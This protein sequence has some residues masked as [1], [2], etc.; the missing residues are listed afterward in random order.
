MRAERTLLRRA[1]RAAGACLLLSGW[2]ATA[3]AQGWSVQFEQAQ[4]AD[5]VTLRL[6][7]LHNPGGTPVVL[8]HGIG[9][10]A[11]EFLLPGRALGE[12][13]AGLG[14]D[15]WCANFRYAGR[16]QLASDDAG[17][18]SFDALVAFDLPAIL[19]RVRAASGGARP[20]LLGHSMGGMV[21]LAWA[22]GIERARV[23]VSLRLVLRGGRLR[24]EPV[25][26]WRMR[27][28]PALAA[29]RAAE[30]R[31]VIAIGSPARLRWPLVLPRLDPDLYW[32]VNV[33]L[34][35]LAWS[36][37]AN[38][39][40]LPLERIPASE[41][42]HA[43]TVD[44][45]QLPHVGPAVRAYLLWVAATIG[46]SLLSAQFM[47]P[48][49]ID[50]AT[51]YQALAAAADDLPAGA[52]RQYLDAI[53][54]RDM[55]EAHVLDPVRAPLS[56]ADSHRFIAAP[57]LWVAGRFDKIANDDAIEAEFSA[58]ATPDKTLLRVDHG[59]LD[60]VI[61][62]RAPQDVWPALVRWLAQH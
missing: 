43:L 58:L 17:E 39:A 20:F 10:N 55:R 1:A 16:G 45:P 13:L 52:V 54:T 27:A 23:P 34:S 25:H 30:I 49:S 59:H 47:L 33:V 12:Y 50:P 56:Y 44:L 5:G 61:G 35:S 9:A 46:N 38:L 62:D 60:L 26:G 51:S 48:G 36:P 37:A 11:Q 18:S 41:V 19:D 29:R 32:D 31:G 42:V 14:Y 6:V 3:H 7:R 22:A 8:L 15:V 4:T 40:L 24:L 57:V 21:A 28:E 2:A 53:R